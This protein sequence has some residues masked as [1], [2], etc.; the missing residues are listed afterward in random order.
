MHK[1]SAI[2]TII[3]P[4]FRRLNF[5]QQALRSIKKQV[6]IN[7]KEIRIV[8]CDEEYSKK[9]RE[10]LKSIFPKLVYLRNK[11]DEGPGGNRQ[12]GLDTVKTKYVMFLDS[13]D[14]LTPNFLITMIEALESN[15][16]Q[17]AAICLSEPHFEPGFDVLHRLKLY[18]LMI[19]R[20]ISLLATIF[21]KNILFPG[22]FYLCQLSHMLFRAESL[23]TFQFNYSYRFGGEDWDLLAKVT[24]RGEILV[25]LKRLLNFRYSPGS[26]TEHPV[27]QRNKWKSYRLLLSKLPQR[28]KN[29]FF[30]KLLL[31]YIGMFEPKSER[32]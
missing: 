7:A 27:N 30:F 16:K 26:S 12:T 32:K 5:T 1:D 25:V 11:H 15:P 14:Q 13:D 8:V 31:Y 6:G 3:I 29:G 28:R 21:H 24:G 17:V 23:K 10:K 18:P 4:H 2:V 9:T 19:I 20:D 22:A